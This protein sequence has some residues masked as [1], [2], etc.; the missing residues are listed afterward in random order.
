MPGI[1]N[2]VTETKEYIENLINKESPE[3][4][5]MIGNSMGGF[6]AILFSALI[7][8]SRAVA[9]APQTFISPLKRLCC[10]DRRWRKEIINTYKQSWN[11]KGIWNL[12]RLIPKGNWSADIYVS[13]KVR[14]DYVHALN[15]SAFPG[16]TIH[17]YD[18]GGHGL[19]KELRD[20]GE[21][22]DILRGKNQV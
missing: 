18:S 19:V 13:K 17:E 1:S 11:R 15:L 14:L 12:N 5:I 20:K 16:V 9:F 22:A 4:T 8:N 10:R 3:E 6:A 2:N 21:L 7:G